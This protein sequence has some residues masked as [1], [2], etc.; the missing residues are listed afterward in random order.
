MTSAD[1]SQVDQRF[2][3]NA[4]ASFIQ[5]GAVLFLLYWC[6]T[7]IAPFI[8]VVV[9][10]LIISV[11]IYPAH[12]VLSARLGGRAKLSAALLVLAGLAIL[13]V[14]TGYLAESTFNALRH[15]A[16]DLEDGAV[17]IPP[18]AESVA[19]WPLI[20]EPLYAAWSAAATNF[21]AALNKYTPQLKSLGQTALAFAG[22]TVVGVLQFVLAIIIAGAFL[23]SA[24]TGYRASR[25]I[26]VSL[27]G[28]ERGEKLTDLSILTIRSV[29]K[30][31]LG[32]A[33]I[34]A[35]L[36]AIG[37]V[38]I[39]VPAAGL[40]A[41]AVLVLAII[42]LP[43][44]L[45]LGPIA[46]WVFSVMDGLPATIFLVYA[47]FVSTSDAFLKPMFLG[48][49]VDVPMLVI[50]IGAIGGAMSQGIIGLFTGAVVLALGYEIITAWMTP[51]ESVNDLNQKA[52]VTD[53]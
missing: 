17:S 52:S 22:G 46:I 21:E 42:Q 41:A 14:P 45:V 4:M 18:P 30:G 8:H 9:W 11:A 35:I 32:V 39:G 34:Q 29:T 1:S 31:V 26:A 40:W 10:G 37:L 47:I 49:G 6:F 24:G 53:R 28:A 19:D 5:I 15:I 44:V 13:L 51:D 3:A 50:L 23:T 27:I 43:P 12:A 7:I 20:G 36:S 33:I 48:R 2:L 25:N 16:T 38:A